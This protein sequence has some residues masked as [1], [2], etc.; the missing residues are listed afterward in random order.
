M[1]STPPS[2]HQVVGPHI[3]GVKMPWLHC[4]RCEKC[5]FESN[6]SYQWGIHKY[7]LSD[8]TEATIRCTSGWCHSCGDF[9]LIEHLPTTT[10]LSDE[11][12]TCQSELIQIQNHP[13]RKFFRQQRVKRKILKNQCDDLRALARVISL[14]KRPMP[15][16][17]ECG[18][19]EAMPIE[20]P[21]T[22]GE[23]EKSAHVQHPNCGGFFRIHLPFAH[24][25]LSVGISERVY[26]V[27]G[28]L[29]IEKS[30]P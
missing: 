1:F 12:Q 23:T 21:M 18:S 28:D 8:G 20:F 17:L 7:R 30:V 6:N 27:E 3:A 24:L 2:G 22:S 14:R 19:T 5:G 29:I 25:Y 26:D 4:I 10:E 9:R 16:C 15:R 11:L 13:I